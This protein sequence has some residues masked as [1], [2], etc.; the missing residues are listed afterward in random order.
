MRISDW[1]SDV[2][3]AD[4]RLTA[5][6]GRGRVVPAELASDPSLA[7]LAG[8]QMGDLFDA[9]GRATAETLVRNGRPTRLLHVDRVDEEAI[10]GLM[11]HYFL[12]TLISAPQNRRAS[13]GENEGREG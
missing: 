9:E 2:C 3:S 11:I 6:A 4:L 5:C 10:G 7:Y 13:W 1:S 12:A 8:R